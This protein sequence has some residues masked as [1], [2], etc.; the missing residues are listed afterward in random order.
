MRRWT[1]TF[2]DSQ[3]ISYD[4][5]FSGCMAEAGGADVFAYLG[6]PRGCAFVN[7][8]MEGHADSAIK[9][10]AAGGLAIHGCYFEGNGDDAGYEIEAISSVDTS[11]GVSILGNL[12]SHIASGSYTPFN[13]EAI[14][15]ELCLAGES[16][17]N[18]FV[19]R[20][21]DLKS[22]GYTVNSQVEINDWSSLAD[23][24]MNGVLSGTGAA[25]PMFMVQPASAQENIASG[26]NITVVFGTERYD[27]NGD[28][29][30][31]TFTAPRTGRYHFDVHVRLL[32][33]DGAADYY[34]A[35]LITDFATYPVRA[36]TE[37]TVDSGTTDSTT[38]DMLEDAGQNFSTTV[39]GGDNVYNMTDNTIASVTV[40][41]DN[42]TLSLSS[43]IMVSGEAYIITASQDR[44]TYPFTLGVDCQM[45]AGHTA[46][47][48][49][50]QASGSAQTDIDTSSWFS[51]RYIGY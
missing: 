2:F 15:W 9:Y 8:L 27:R 42:D 20:G 6:N 23:V 37:H 28:F 4:I 45:Q 51:G 25:N 12:I 46:Y 40:V 32:N 49:V 21:H 39:T 10:F 5:R 18:Y 26:S 3:N 14:H 34:D 33:L 22:T 13:E 38:A 50:K 41:D 31:N 44:P 35:Y 16:K 36:E 19:G 43:D 48:A 30:A 17:G 47:V 24:T 1:G 7:T 29:A 11:Y